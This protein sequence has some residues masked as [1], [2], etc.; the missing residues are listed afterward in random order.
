MLLALSV[1]RPE[2]KEILVLFLP[3]ILNFR[4]D[5]ASAPWSGESERADTE[6]PTR[7]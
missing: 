2:R 5:K 4:V 6:A 3:L 7:E 1:G